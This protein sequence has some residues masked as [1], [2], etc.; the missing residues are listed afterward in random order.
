MVPAIENFDFKPFE[1]L[2]YDELKVVVDAI[3]IWSEEVGRIELWVGKDFD[4]F[5]RA[6]LA[7]EYRIV[8][9]EGDEVVAIADESKGGVLGGAYRISVNEPR[10]L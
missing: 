1:V 4:P 6:E 8:N 10:I 9:T 2:A 3:K 5:F 7:A